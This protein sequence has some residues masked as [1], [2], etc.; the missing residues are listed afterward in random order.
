M[1]YHFGPHEGKLSSDFVFSANIDGDILITF[2]Q[3]GNSRLVKL[4]QFAGKQYGCYEAI[5]S[6]ILHD[7]PA[8]ASVY[9]TDAGK[10]AINNQVF[11]NQRN[12]IPN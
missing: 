12:Q 7:Y 8:T 5:V 9:I 10:T 2:R 4:D 6:A 3:T 11:K 1:T